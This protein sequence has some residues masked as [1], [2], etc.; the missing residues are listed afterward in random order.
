MVGGSFPFGWFISL[1]GPLRREFGHEDPDV[2][3]RLR[4]VFVSDE[5]VEVGAAPGRD[6][7]AV[8]RSG[9]VT[10][11]RCASDDS[12]ETAVAVFLP[13]TQLVNRGGACLRELRA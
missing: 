5:S 11:G 13:S 10:V 3:S 12:R 1:K 8:S 2:A 7:L 6:G 9:Q 4:I